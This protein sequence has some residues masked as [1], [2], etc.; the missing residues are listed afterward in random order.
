M[1]V[2]EHS[3]SLGSKI[4]ENTQDLNSLHSSTTSVKR[5]V[6]N[7]IASGTKE[8]TN[9]RRTSDNVN[10]IVKAI[11]GD[12]DPNR[13][14]ASDANKELVSVSNLADWI[15]GAIDNGDG[16]VTL[17]STTESDPIFIASAAAGIS[18]SDMSNWDAKQDALLAGVDY[19]VPLT[20]EAPLFRSSD[21]IVSIFKAD[22]SANG[23]LSKEDWNTFNSKQ[24][25]GSYLTVE[26]D[27]VWNS[28]KSGYSL[29]THSH[30]GVY[31]VLL[32]FDLPLSRDSNDVVSI[33]EEDPIFIASV[34]YGITS[35]LVT[36]WNTAYSW[37]DH[38][39]IGYLTHLNFVA[40]TDYEL[41]LTFDA[42]LYKS[43]DDV[44]SIF[45]AT[46]LVDGYLSH[47]DWS[48][49]NSKQPAL[50]GSILGTDNQVNVSANSNSV[51]VNITLSGPQDI[52]TGASP[53]FSSLT[54]TH[55][56]LGIHQNTS[57][58]SDTKSIAV[59]GGGGTAAN[60]G[61]TFW[62]FGN[63]Y[64]VAGWKGVMLIEAGDTYTSWLDGSIILETHS[65]DR[66]FVEYNGNV[67]I[68]GF[69][70]VG[71][72]GTGSINRTP[73]TKLEVLQTDGNPQL[74]LSYGTST[75][76][77]LGS[78]SSGNFVIIP[79]SGS[80]SGLL[81]GTSGVVSAAVAGTDYD[82]YLTRTGTVLTARTAGDTLTI[83]NITDSGLTITRIPYASTA[84]LL[85]DV[86]GFTIDV[87]N[88]N[89]PV[90]T[91]IG[92]ASSQMLFDAASA[93]IGLYTDTDLMTITSG[94]INVA[95]L[96][97]C[98]TFR[99]DQ[100][101]AAGTITPDKTITISCDGVDYEV[102]V[103]AA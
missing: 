101:P 22:V 97:E 30:N 34:A 11:M 20:F 44:I 90:E 10:E 29:I 49:F 4:R 69:G 6:E 37:G 83:A 59:S 93:L 26:I 85:V 35:G 39:T 84:G 42:P 92:G 96:V 38:A 9:E 5:V 28:E 1:T 47:V 56:F 14:V 3:S 68:G 24:P 87:S 27:P 36:N 99:L 57:D 88:F 63:E 18:L 82:N 48:T 53:T 91:I 71:Q 62:C 45:K 16:T 79:S 64:I 103:K 23:Y 32:T 55:S 89:V 33:T 31:E 77:T 86:A 2:S 7:S 54:L 40:G 76:I 50:T 100:T 13:L 73:N 70:T 52:H 58:G 81:L 94:V 46:A 66:L 80:L 67:G 98:D 43:S 8:H 12:L 15:D 60:R 75:Y 21:D 74:K 102:A 61:A 95:G 17:P 78:D 19:E 41:P 25:A 65:L 72:S 51:A